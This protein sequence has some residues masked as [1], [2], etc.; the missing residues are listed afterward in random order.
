MNTPL[1]LLAAVLL[2]TGAPPALANSNTDLTVTGMITPSACEPSLSSG[3][4]V[5]HGKVEMKDL[6]PDQPTRLETGT[7]YLEVNCEAATLFTLTT[8][9]NRSGSSAIHPT[10]HGLGIVND[11]EKLG[12]VALGLFDA[13]ADGAAVKTIMS[14]DEGA[15]WRVSSYLGHAGR[16]AFAALNAPGTPIAIKVL[17]ARLTAF[18]TIVRASDLTLTDEIP[19]DGHVTVQLNY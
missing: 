4:V 1:S 10:H 7:L 6:D 3:G 16:T 15:S 9:D 13:I 11:D 8:V 12:S 18:T 14:R 19:I 5:E 17:R 2:L